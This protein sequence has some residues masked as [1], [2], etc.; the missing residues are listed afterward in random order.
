LDTQISHAIFILDS[1]NTPPNFQ[2]AN[3]PMQEVPKAL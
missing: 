3:L 1:D 2:S